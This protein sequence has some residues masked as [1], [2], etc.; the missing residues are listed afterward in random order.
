[1][2]V[3]S[4]LLRLTAGVTND[5]LAALAAELDVG[6]HS[7][8]LCLACLSFVA[9]ADE[10]DERAIRREIVEIAPGLWHDGFGGAV[11]AALEAVLEAG[12]VSGSGSGSG[13][14]SAGTALRDL[15]ERKWRSEIFRAVIRRLSVELRHE[16]RRSYYASLN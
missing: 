13:P 16:A 10:D 5:R 12:S 7:P 4:H 1:V 3:S 15:D 9:C 8:G 6:L 2:T 14:A 11:R